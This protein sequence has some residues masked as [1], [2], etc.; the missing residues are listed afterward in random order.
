MMMTEK[1]WEL[2]CIDTG[3]TMSYENYVKAVNTIIQRLKK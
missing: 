3:C 1:E 2:H